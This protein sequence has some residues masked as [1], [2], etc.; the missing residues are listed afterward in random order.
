MVEFQYLYRGLCGLARAHRA[1]TMAGHLG[2]AVTAGYFFGEELPDL[3]PRVTAAVE[4]E[5]D[6]IIAGEE[7]SWFN[8]QRAHITIGELFEP[9]PEAE[10]QPDRIAVIADALAANIDQTRQSG[11]N[12]IFAAIAIRALKDHP[13]YATDEMVDGIRRLIAGFNGA[14]P[15]RGYYGKDRGWISG[16]NVE[17]PEQ[18]DVPQYESLPEMAEVVV[19]ELIESGGVHR[20]GFGGLFHLINHAAAL[21]ELSHYGFEELA[22]RGLPAHHQHL[23]L[24]RSLPD[25]EEELGK[26]VRAR[27]DPRTPAY[28]DDKPSEQWSAR[29]THRIKTLYGFH[30][31]LRYIDNEQKRAA[32]R[33]QF[34]YLMG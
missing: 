10:P 27:H 2:A 22:R 16:E 21:T 33:E 34:L 14:V 29:L 25:L 32:A 4:G 9:L 19:A 15:G 24:L 6:R 20:Q 31:L 26:L 28:W 23:R 8:Q 18:S 12:V 17:F 1:N 7:G 11:H 5:L 30:M 3:D 13:E